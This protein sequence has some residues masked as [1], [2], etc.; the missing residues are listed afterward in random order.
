MDG[1]S[2]TGE[3]ASRLSRVAA[4]DGLPRTSLARRTALA[5]GGP[6]APS[7]WLRT[8]GAE[9][10]VPGP[11]AVLVM[12]AH[13]SRGRRPRCGAR[14]ACPIGRPPDREARR[15]A[16]GSR[17]RRRRRGGNE[18]AH[19]RAPGNGAAHRASQRRG[20]VRP[21]LTFVYG[22]C[23]F[24]RGVGDPWAAFAVA[25]SSYAWL[26]RDEKRARMLALVGAIEAAEA[27]VQILRVAGRWDPTVTAPTW[28][29]RQIASLSAGATS[30]RTRASSGSGPRSCLRSTCS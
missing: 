2:T 25:L 18:S 19:R 24:A 14:R 15:T 7:G 10:P 16:I 29:L 8:R 4:Q 3:V 23:V 26:D 5:P 20:A 17:A 11:G 1:R 30:R 6:P 27:D 13:R 12:V 28:R 9:L 22:N 21:P